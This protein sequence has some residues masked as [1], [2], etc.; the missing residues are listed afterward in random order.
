MDSKNNVFR[1][2]NMTYNFKPREYGI[3]DWIYRK[4]NIN[5]IVTETN[6]TC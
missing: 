4:S 2:A 5:C 3:L 6:T 1:K